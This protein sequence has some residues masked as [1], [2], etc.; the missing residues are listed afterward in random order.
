MASRQARICRLKNKISRRT[1][2]NEW[3][4]HQ[5]MASFP[6]RIGQGFLLDVDGTGEGKMK[7]NQQ[8][9][10]THSQVN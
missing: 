3:Q 4:R 2:R 1:R 9:T 8:Q 7:M 5:L 6:K 10:L